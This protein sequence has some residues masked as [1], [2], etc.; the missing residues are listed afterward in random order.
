[1]EVAALVRLFLL[2]NSLTKG[3]AL[4]LLAELARKYQMNI[5]I[6][7]Y[8]S[9]LGDGCC[10]GRSSVMLDVS[11]RMAM[12]LVYKAIT[13]GD[14]YNTWAPGSGDVGRILHLTLRPY[15]ILGYLVSSCTQEFNGPSVFGGLYLWASLLLVLSEKR[16]GCRAR[17]PRMKACPR[18]LSA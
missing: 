12:L 14:I 11:R 13:F 16:I 3:A 17:L 7:A 8:K 18:W 4:V 6:G 5:V 10:I 9:R 15:R 2:L 1:M